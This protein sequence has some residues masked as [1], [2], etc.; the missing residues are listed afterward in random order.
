VVTP[1]GGIGGFGGIVKIGGKLP[2]SERFN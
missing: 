1:I 2:K